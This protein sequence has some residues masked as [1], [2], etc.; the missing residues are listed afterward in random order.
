[1][2]TVIGVF[3]REKLSVEEALKRKQYSFN[4][5][6]DVEVGDYIQTEQYVNKIQIITIIVPAYKYVS[7]KTGELS[8]TR[9]DDSVEIRLINVM[10]D[11]DQSENLSEI[12]HV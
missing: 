8:N 12:K 1:M 2:K 5:A 6:D 11:I 10:K 9:E 3:T 4:C 7:V